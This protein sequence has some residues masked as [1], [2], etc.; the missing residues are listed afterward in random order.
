[1]FL[2]PCGALGFTMALKA[3]I[4]PLSHQKEVKKKDYVGCRIYLNK[5]F[6]RLIIII[7]ISYYSHNL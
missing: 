6:K 3:F 5:L 7:I 2:F 4:K 1:M